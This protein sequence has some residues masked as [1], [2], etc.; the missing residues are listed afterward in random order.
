MSLYLPQ[1]SPSPL[2]KSPVYPVAQVDLKN[3]CYFSPSVFP[4]NILTGSV[5][6]TFKI[7]FEGI[8]FLPSCCY[9]CSLRSCLL[10]PT[11]L[12]NSNHFLTSFPTS[13][14]LSFSMYQWAFF[15][16]CFF[17]S[18]GLSKYESGLHALNVDQILNIMS[19]PV[20]SHYTW[21]KIKKPYL[22]RLVGLVV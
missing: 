3:N 16:V 11:Q 19:T 20:D 12:H 4:F 15:F 18:S 14:I 13:T 1:S 17:R 22:G 7:D 5:T 2:I 10:L 21:N 9:P 6:S 8:V